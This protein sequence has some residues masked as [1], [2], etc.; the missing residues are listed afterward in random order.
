MQHSLHWGTPKNASCCRRRNQK[1]LEASSRRLPTSTRPRPH[2]GPAQQ[3]RDDGDALGKKHGVPAAR[4]PVICPNDCFRKLVVLFLGVLIIRA[5]LV[6][7]YL[8]AADFGKTSKQ[9]E[10]TGEESQLSSTFCAKN[11]FTSFLLTP[12]ATRL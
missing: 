9:Y 5:L 2:K 6:W 12:T 8:K 10:I 4:A 1:R 11:A 3:L 7:I